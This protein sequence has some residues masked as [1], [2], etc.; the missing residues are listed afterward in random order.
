M[1]ANVRMEL[2]LSFTAV[3]EHFFFF[4][5]ATLLNTTANGEIEE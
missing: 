2:F 1:E 3:C 4:E 5:K